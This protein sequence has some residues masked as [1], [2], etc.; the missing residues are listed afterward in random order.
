MNFK[1]LESKL[2][3]HKI[4]YKKVN[5]KIIIGKAKIDFVNYIGLGI[6]PIV[7]GLG[8]LIFLI[9]NIRILELGVV[10]IA[11]G[12]IFLLSIGGFNIWKSK[13]KKLANSFPKVFRENK[14]IIKYPSEDYQLDINTIKEIRLNFNPLDKENFEG[15]LYIVDIKN[16][17]HFILRLHDENKKYIEDDLKWFSDF[18]L[19]QTELDSQ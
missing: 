7:C 10:H 6:M 8:I 15:N 5:E 3:R 16:Q 17:I 11:A 2:K 19:K 1:I 13:R 14:I 12:A 9:M 18:I 4:S